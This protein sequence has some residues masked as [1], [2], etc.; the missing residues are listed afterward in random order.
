MSPW[1]RSETESLLTSTNR[2]WQFGHRAETAS[3]SSVSSVLQS[4]V[5]GEA[6]GRGELWPYSLT[7]LKHPLAV[8]QAGSPYAAR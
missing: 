8:V 2:M 4:L 3:R 5:G 1:S 6:L 7:F